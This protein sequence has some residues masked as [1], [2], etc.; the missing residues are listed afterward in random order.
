M[1]LISRAIVGVE[2]PPAWYV[3][4]GEKTV[5]PVETDLLVR[6]VISGK[7]P[8]ECCVSLTGEGWRP[9]HQ[10]REVQRARLGLQGPNEAIPGSVRHSIRWLSDARDVGEAFS[11]TL[12][13]ACAVTNAQVGVLYRWRQPLERPVV[14]ACFGD[15]HLELGEV[16][17]RCDPALWAAQEGEPTVMAPEDSP[18]ARAMAFRLSPAVRLAGLALVPLRAATEVVGV[19]ELGRF[20]H[21]FRNTDARSLVPLVTAMIARVEEL[22]WEPAVSPAPAVDRRSLI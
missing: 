8:A 6:G 11:L 12:H 2:A 15:P 5:G 19:I 21:A 10:V 16:V 14:S 17:S 20:D 1:Q 3:S 9:I 4:N 13:G 18:A 7:I 22:S